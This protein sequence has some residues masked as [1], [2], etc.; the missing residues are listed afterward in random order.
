MGNFLSGL[1]LRSGDVLTHWAIDSHTELQ[2][3]FGLIDNG[4]GEFAKVELTPGNGDWLAPETWTFHLDE[5]TAPAWWDEVKDT[6]EKKLRARA[7]GMVRKGGTLKH[8]YDGCYILGDDA[9]I[10]NLCG[11]RVIQ[12]RDSASI[13]GVW[14]SASIRDVR[15]SA[16]ISDDKRKKK[17]P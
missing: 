6:A 14:G 3:H 8:V 16:S 4:R 1:A 15:D 7:E 10:E 12:M 17:A 2:E 5:E 9:R 13:R 11:G